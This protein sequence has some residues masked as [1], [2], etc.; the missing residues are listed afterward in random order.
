[1]YNRQEWLDEFQDKKILIWGYGM[2]GESSYRFIRSLLPNQVIDITDQNHSFRIDETIHTNFLEE[3]NCDFHQYDL[4][5]KAP[6]IV[7]PIELLDCA[8]SGQAPL[9][10]KHYKD[11]VIG[12]TGTKGKSTTTSLIRDVLH[13]KRRCHLV[14]NIG[15]ACFDVIEEMKEDDLVAF[16]ISCHQLEFTKDSPHIAIFLNLYEEHLDHYKSFEKYKEAKEK[17]Y[18]FQ[19]PGDILYIHEDLRADSKRDDALVIGKDVYVKD[20]IAHVKEHSIS[21]EKSSLIGVHNEL[22]QAIAYGIGLTYG[23]SDEEFLQAIESFQPLPHR[24]QV[25]GTKDG[26]T[27]VDD[28]ISTIG[29]SCVNAIRSLKETGSVLI[30]GMD[31]GIDYNDLKDFLKSQDELE[32]IFMYATGK[33]IYEEMKEEGILPKRVHFVEDLKEAVQLAKEVT[34]KGRICLLSP[35]DSSYDHFKNF[36]ERGDVFKHLAL[37]LCGK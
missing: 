29:M 27:Y 35:A 16:E 32:V 1:M 5:L 2:E 18:R 21:L 3:K 19:K 15:K 7:V 31:R 12:V 33:R 34:K 36:E 11:R 26:I 37:D 20:H 24:L 8:I 23:I 25:I 30:G 14:G 17:I 10:L 28:S 6:G 13:T 22:N 4:I 9:F